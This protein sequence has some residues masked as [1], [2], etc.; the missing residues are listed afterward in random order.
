MS[1]ILQIEST[2]PRE[3]PQIAPIEIPKTVRTNIYCNIVVITYPSVQVL[4]YTKMCVK[5]VPNS[6]L[7][8]IFTGKR[9]SWI[10]T[11]KIIR[12]GAKNDA[13]K[14]NIAL[15]PILWMEGNQLTTMSNRTLVQ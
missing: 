14:S 8:G 13:L 1:G 4:E 12:T 2:T 6:N 10:K 7:N 5:E 15:P 3:V 9:N 11:V